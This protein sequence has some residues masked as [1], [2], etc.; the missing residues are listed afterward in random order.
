[1]SCRNTA[2]NASYGSSGQPFPS[3]GTLARRLDSP[4][5]SLRRVI[6]PTLQEHP[7]YVY[8][9][10]SAKVQ[11]GAFVQ[12]GSAPNFQGGLISICACKHEDRAS[13]S[14]SGRRGPHAGDPW[15][16]VSVAGL[17]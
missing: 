17:C 10:T 7:L 1:M 6:P 2:P 4:L 14:P 12:E 16:D 3:S 5:H 8:I 9:V 11:A 13:P 15:K